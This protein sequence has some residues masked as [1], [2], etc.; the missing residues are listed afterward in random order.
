MNHLAGL[1]ADQDGYTEAEPLYRRALAI[2]ETARGP[3]HPDVTESV[4]GLA[5]LYRLEGRYAE[6]EPLYQRLLALLEKALGP[7]HPRRGGDS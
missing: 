5:E 2:F 1:Y 3:D 4:A 7:D 6:A